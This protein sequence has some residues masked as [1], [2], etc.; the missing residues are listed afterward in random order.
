MSK[1]SFRNTQTDFTVA[2]K[3]SV[4]EYFASSKLKTTGNWKLYSKTIV[5]LL[6][7]VATWTTLL[8]IS[9]P[10]WAS[11][12]LCMLLGLNLAAIGFN[13]MHDG[14]H[15]SYSAKGWINEVMSYTPNLM[16]GNVYFWKV[17]HNVIHH[18]Y[19]NIE[20][21]DDDIN[22]RPLMRTNE[23]Q[24]KLRI[25]RYQH[26]YWPVLYSMTHFWWVFQR[27]FLKYFTGK[28]AEH[29]IKKMNLREHL[30]FWF[31]KLVYIFIFIVLPIILLGPVA[32]VGYAI[33]T[34]SAGLVLSVVFQL[35][36]VVEHT[37]FPVADIATDKIEET[38]I[39]HQL[40][41]TANFSTRSRIVTWFTG[42][43]NFQVEHHLFPRISHV[44]YPAI[45][46][47]VKQLCA[48]FNVTYIEYPTLFRALRSHI[49]Y[50][51]VIGSR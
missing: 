4:E 19:T 6:A 17:K 14:A 42:G 32:L 29:K 12:V 45:H 27:D 8:F 11:I 3:K 44:H 25:H 2:L 35:A 48:E 18:S 50:L 33:V 39:I 5:L 28:I 1:I 15:G 13:I 34:A 26:I 37:E 38:W 41:T 16:G 31:S 40:N 24:P 21:H 10:A 47:R 22:I 23:H 30:I 36:H 51:R 49:A 46:K 20:G 9:I 7:A 43:L